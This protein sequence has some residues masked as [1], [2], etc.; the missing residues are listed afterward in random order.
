VAA[1]G[2]GPFENDRAF[3]WAV[4]LKDSSD[5]GL[6]R[7]TITQVLQEPSVST[8]EGFRGIAACE[9]IAIVHG[10]PP[11]ASELIPEEVF[12]WAQRAGALKDLELV[13]AALEA[14]DQI[15][16][17]ES[18]LRAISVEADNPHWALKND[19]LRG[20]LRR[21]LEPR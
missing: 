13:K 6:P 1:W 16:G 17:T 11:P 14:L 10:A 12:V 3:Y 8:N 4:S 21:L 15:E 9:A 2:A 18:E 7:E 19:D 5:L 20:R